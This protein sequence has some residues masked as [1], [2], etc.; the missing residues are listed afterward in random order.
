MYSNSYSRTTFGL[1]A[2][3]IHK[4]KGKSCGYYMRIVFFFSSLIQS[5]IIVSLVLFLVYGQPE[6]SAEEKRVE[7]LEQGFNKLSTDNMGL[8]KDKA[9]LTASLTKTTAEKDALDKNVQ[10][11]TDELTKAKA[12]GT[13]QSQKAAVCEAEKKKMEMTRA[14]PVQCPATSNTPNG[15]LKSLQNLYQQQIELHKITKANFSSTVQYL[16][17]DLENAV[18]AKNEHYLTSISLRQENTDLKNQLETY[19]TKCKEDFA[20]PLE[21]IHIVTREFLTKIEN[22]FPN[23]FTFHLTCEKQ[24][25]EMDKIRSSCTNLSKQVEDKFQ[26]YLD[27]V[28]QQVVNIQSI[29]SRLEVQNTR[30]TTELQECNK[31]RSLL[32][33]ETARLQQETQQSHDNQIEKLLREQN[34]MREAKELMERQL[35]QLRASQTNCAPKS[36]MPKPGGAVSGS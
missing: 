3:D 36:A 33:T 29:S 25:D 14:T 9:D 17:T 21:G 23:A 2:K 32:A 30:L 6:K 26:S 24:R 13:S 4:S 27:I 7:E 31:S 15:E 12:L 1:E 20:K 16:K 18:R 19:V 28:G 22:L 10:K 34:R 5:L 8:R 11:L 35:A